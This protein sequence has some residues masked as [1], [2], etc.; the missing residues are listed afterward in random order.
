[1][2]RGEIDMNIQETLTPEVGHV[3]EEVCPT[4]VSDLA[5]LLVV[6]VSRVGTAPTHDHGG[7]VQADSMRKVRVV[8]DSGLNIQRESE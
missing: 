7:A 2:G 6:P 3:A 1:M 4:G 5:H 8:N